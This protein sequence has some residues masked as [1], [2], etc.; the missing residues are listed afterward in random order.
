M[1]VHEAAK[2]LDKW[3]QLFI[4]RGFYQCTR[5][6]NV[7]KINKSIPILDHDEVEEVAEILLALEYQKYIILSTLNRICFS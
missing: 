5:E 7:M 3:I 1:R 4:S 6:H 2:K